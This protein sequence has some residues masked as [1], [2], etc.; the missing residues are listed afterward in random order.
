LFLTFVLVLHTAAK[1]AK[2]NANT[3]LAALQSYETNDQKRPT[4]NQLK[5]QTQSE[6]LHALFDSLSHGVWVVDANCHVRYAN[7]VAKAVCAAICSCTA[8]CYKPP[9]S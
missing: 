7:A 6:G 8:A 2:M 1:E 4:H 9:A 3:L 5:P